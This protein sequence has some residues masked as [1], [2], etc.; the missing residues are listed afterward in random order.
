MTS[1]DAIAR[2]VELARDLQLE[3]DPDL[4][5]DL[6]AV[7]DDLGVTSPEGVAAQLLEFFNIHRK[8]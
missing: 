6:A 2:I 3:P 4:L 8:D 7:L 1:A 5:S